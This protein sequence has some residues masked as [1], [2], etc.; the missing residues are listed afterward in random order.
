L[1]DKPKITI[2]TAT[3]RQQTVAEVF[4]ECNQPVIKHHYKVYEK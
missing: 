4:S 1:N 3:H 2:T